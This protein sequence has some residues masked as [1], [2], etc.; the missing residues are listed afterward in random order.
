MARDEEA[1][2]AFV[3]TS[4]SR[5]RRMAYLMCGDW[6]IAEDHTQEA[7]IRMFVKWNRV[8]E[9]GRLAY[10]RRVLTR[11][12]IDESRKARHKRERTG[13][14]E[15]RPANREAV[16]AVADNVDLQRA[17]ASL[18]ARQRACVVL[19]FVDD[20]SVADTASA[21]NTSQ[22]TVKSQTAKALEHLRSVLSPSLLPAVGASA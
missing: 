17:L 3:D 20:L 10:A 7:L 2:L 22:G 5:L 1:Y 16:A 11:I 15:D 6:Q 18:P 13:D 12:I 4:A 8:E 9:S 19:R 14:L 21:M